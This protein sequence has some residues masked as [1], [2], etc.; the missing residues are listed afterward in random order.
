M[1]S[2]TIG[3]TLWAAALYGQ[4]V[5]GGLNVTGPLDASGAPATR[6]ARSGSGIPGAP[7]S[8][9]E[10]FFNVAAGPG[11]NLYLCNP[12]NTWTQ[13][14][15]AA[16]GGNSG[17]L[18]FDGAET[19]LAD[20]A[21]I[22]WTTGNGSNGCAAGQKCANWSVP[23]GVNWVRVQIWGGGGGGTGGSAGSGAGAGGGGGGYY[24]T[25]CPVTPGALVPV[26][27]GMGGA[28]SGGYYTGATTGGNSSLGTCVTVTGGEAGVVVSSARGWGGSLYGAARV[29]WFRGATVIDPA[30]NICSSARRAWNVFQN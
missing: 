29:G 25:T 24:E 14:S 30:S 3:L 6:P 22:S 5:V 26:A 12:D 4:A 11:Q 1:K 27:V 18:I 13:L 23:T 15:S 21:T 7:C 28:G 2:I 8:S 9:G 10:V 20:G 19:S 16:A 17:P